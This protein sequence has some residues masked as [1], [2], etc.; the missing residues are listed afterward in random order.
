MRVLALPLCLC[1]CAALAGTPMKVMLDDTPVRASPS[2]TA[3][4][5]GTSPRYHTYVSTEVQGGWHKVWFSSQTGWIE[6]SRLAVD[7]RDVVT[8]TASSGNVRSGPGTDN[9]IVGT[10][11]AG[12]Q[13]MVIGV[14][15]TQGAWKQLYYGGE[16]RWMHQSLLQTYDQP[17]SN[18]GFVQVPQGGEGFYAITSSD[19]LWGL[20]RLVYPL[21][22][23]ARQFT[24][25]N[26]GW[27]KIGVNDLSFK[28][29]G[30]MSPHSSHQIGNDADIRLLRTDAV[31][32]TTDIYQPTYSRARTKTLI[33]NYFNKFLDL[34]VILFGDRYVYGRLTST[35]TGECTQA[36]IS[37]ALQYVACYPDHWHH[38][39]VRVN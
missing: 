27:G 12:T 39:H 21:M 37:T 26:P 20:P 32:E 15:G 23:S 5:V 4:L 6:A 31:L 18:A 13:W 9:R 36:P 1:A 19:R 11:S 25:D 8:V 28:N 2:A 38:L 33:T 29:G 10:T 17:T 14:G 22:D 3:A 7:N 34:N 35:R 30:A 16:I 24:R